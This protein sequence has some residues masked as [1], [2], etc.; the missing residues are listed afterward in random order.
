MLSSIFTRD[1]EFEDTHTRSQR[2]NACIWSQLLS[3][4]NAMAFVL[5]RL[6]LSHK[7]VMF[8][9]NLSSSARRTT[10][11]R[12]YQLII[13]RSSAHSRGGW[14]LVILSRCHWHDSQRALKISLQKLTIRTPT[15]NRLAP[16][17]VK[18]VRSHATACAVF[19]WQQPRASRWQW[20][21]GSTLTS[22]DLCR[23]RSIINLVRCP[24]IQALN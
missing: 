19:H 16:F 15:T 14:Q 3:S 20:N 4:A 1:P 17:P 13:E 22:A 24:H 6:C 9:A 8:L 5:L 23:M 2:R 11:R 7:P 18:Y 10:P 21:C 12:S